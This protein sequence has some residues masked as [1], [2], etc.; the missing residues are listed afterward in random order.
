MRADDANLCIEH[1]PL[2]RTTRVGAETLPQT[3]LALGLDTTMS[4]V[5]EDSLAEILGVGPLEI[6]ALGRKN[7]GNPNR[8]G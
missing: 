8:R 6:V 2:H 1:T 7:I 3:H 4:L 5:G